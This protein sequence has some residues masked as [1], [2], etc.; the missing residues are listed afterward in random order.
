MWVPPLVTDGASIRDLGNALEGDRLGD[1]PVATW[2]NGAMHALAAFN[3]P[4]ALERTVELSYGPTPA[5]AYCAQ[6]TADAVVH[7]WDLS[8]A[9]G[10]DE[11]LP[12][13]LLDFAQREFEPYI[14]S[15][16][17]SGLFDKPV[18]PPPGADAQ[19]RFLARLGR[20]P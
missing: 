7:S 8:R 6:M 12:E 3:T 19:T 2:D 11:R 20:N 14:N 9:I 5:R 18:S 1:E 10:A 16:A 15:L 17:G 13:A 4:G